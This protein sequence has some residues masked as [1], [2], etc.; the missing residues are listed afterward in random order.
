MALFLLLVPV[1]LSARITIGTDL[2]DIDMFW[3]KTLRT[4]V[5]AS[6][7][8]ESTRFVFPIRYGREGN[9]MVSFL[10]CGALVEVEP[11]EDWGL[12]I[13]ASLLKIGWIWGAKAPEEQLYLSAEGSVGWRFQF[14]RFS[15]RPML[16]VRDQLTAEEQGTAVIK[17]I[18]Q[19]SELRASFLVGVEL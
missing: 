16:T 9:N 18:R 1:F 10:E 19:F 3:E 11:I 13:R 6:F 7:S 17:E 15:F 4:E 5:E 12:F 8:V 14:G 2:S